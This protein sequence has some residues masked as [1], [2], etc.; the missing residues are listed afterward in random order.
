M[1][2]YCRFRLEEKSPKNGDKINLIHFGDSEEQ[3]HIKQ[4]A[5]WDESQRFYPWVTDKNYHGH[6]KPSTITHWE[7]R[8]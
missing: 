3:M 2:K 4:P 1:K 8:K 5:T 6:A 7:Y